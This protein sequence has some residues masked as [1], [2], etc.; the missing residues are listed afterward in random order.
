MKGELE[1][2]RG[3]RCYKR[4]NKGKFI[5]GIGKQIRRERLMHRLRERNK[6]QQLEDVDNLPTVPFEVEEILPATSPNQHHHISMDNRQKVQVV[7]WI[8]KN[9]KDPAVKVSRATYLIQQ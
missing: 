8:D 6:R 5:V 2:R 3:K 4:V 7:Q 9:K 1:H